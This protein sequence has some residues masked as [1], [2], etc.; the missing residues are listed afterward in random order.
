[1]VFSDH[2]LSK[3]PRNYSGLQTPEVDALYLKQSTELN[4]EKRRALVKD[5]QKL[6]LPGFGRVVLLWQT[7]HAII[8]K[9][10][11]DYTFQPSLYNNSRFQDVWLGGLKGGRLRDE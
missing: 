11:K 7:R 4:P 5:L 2:Y 8:N 1:M 10:V 6:A 3:A 9:S